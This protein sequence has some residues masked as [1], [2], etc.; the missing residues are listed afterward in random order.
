MLSSITPN[1]N[2]VVGTTVGSALA[3]VIVWGVETFGGVKVPPEVAIAV[4]TILGAF[5][6]H[7]AGF[8]AGEKSTEVKSE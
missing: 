7:A 8:S 1:T 3:T 4:G 5:I 6:G 2:A